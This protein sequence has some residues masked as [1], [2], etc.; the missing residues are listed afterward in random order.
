MFLLLL[1][2][3]FVERFTDNTMYREYNNETSKN[4]KLITKEEFN[5]DIKKGIEIFNESIEKFISFRIAPFLSH[6]VMHDI[7]YDYTS[8][9]LIKW[10]RQGKRANHGLT[11]GEIKERCKA[12]L[13][14]GRCFRYI[15]IMLTCRNDKENIYSIEV[16][17]SVL[18]YHESWSIYCSRESQG[19]ISICIDKETYSLNHDLKFVENVIRMATTLY[20]NL[21][22]K[23][24][25][26]C[27]ID[28][29]IEEMVRI[30]SW[31]YGE[32]KGYEF[33]NKYIDF[34]NGTFK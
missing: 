15:A 34:V 4:S 17:R 13:L 20:L 1:I 26:Q 29:D 6:Q 14:W 25:P 30:A 7:V 2:H 22:V 3:I 10:Y 31:S 11:L 5:Q 16:N 19:P 21:L 33:K 24:T 9:N 28:K 32:L 12:L 8:I 27:W 23:E 18:L